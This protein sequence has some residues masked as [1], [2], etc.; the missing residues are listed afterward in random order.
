[1]NPEAAFLPPEQATLESEYK[2]EL[3]K[4]FG[5]VFNKLITITNMAIG[6][7]LQYLHK[8]HQYDEYDRLLRDS[9][10]PKTLEKL[11]C[12]NQI[13]VGWDGT[14]YDCDYNLALGLPVGF[15]IPRHIGD[16][17]PTAHSKRRIV[18]GNHCFGCAAGHGS[19]CSGALD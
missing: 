9:F 4:N 12:R 16:F 6:R 3:Y 18:T 14:I 1:F 11:M 15:G 8:R 13:D 19:S 5:I 7:F 10:N 17:D 2:E